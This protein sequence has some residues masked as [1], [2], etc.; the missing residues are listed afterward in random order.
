MRPIAATLAVV[1]ACSVAAAP[2][3]YAQ[4]ASVGIDIATK[5]VTI[6]GFPPVT[7]PVPFYAI[8]THAAD[9]YFRHVNEKG[10]I[11][12]WK[13]KYVTYDDGYEPARSVGVAKRLVEDDKVFALV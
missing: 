7:G 9:S 10:G 6:G 12:G 5:T 3:A 13:I 4:D 11:A 2:P 1:A 8:L